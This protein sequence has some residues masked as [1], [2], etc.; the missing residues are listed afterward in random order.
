M[1]C[2]ARSAFLRHAVA[3]ALV[4]ASLAA[5]AKGEKAP[6]STSASGA[7]TPRT[8][9]VAAAGTRDSM[10]GHTQGGMPGMA[11][12]S[13][14]ADHDFLRMMSDHHKGLIQMAH[15]TKD[16]KER[17][18]AV[19]DAMKMDAAQDKELDHMV[20]MLE[21]D[22]KDPYSPK[23]MPEHQAMADALKT[24]KGTEYDRTFYQ[25]VITHHQEAITMI[26]AYLPK[27]GNPMVKQMAEQMKAAQTKEIRAFQ[28][29]VSKLGA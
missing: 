11:N 24:Q 10:A 23:V 17:S 13:G 1:S 28:Q 25:N 12:M 6:D 27:A 14:D 3:S 21:K 9:T 29:K 20:T 2:L 7:S 8:D 4:L 15:M 5:C 18:P 22:F 26:D 19:S 16:R